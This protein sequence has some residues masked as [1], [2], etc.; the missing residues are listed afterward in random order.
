MVFKFAIFAIVGYILFR[1]FA[2]DRKKKEEQLKREE[3][4]RVQQGDLVQ[5]PVCGTYV[6]KENS[7]T[8]RNGEKVIHFCSHDCRD[9]YIKK[10]DA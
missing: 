4:T 10:L 6:E 3:E 2:N 9:Q 5:D 8:V 1:L 7:V